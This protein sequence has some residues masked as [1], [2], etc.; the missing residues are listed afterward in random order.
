[1]TCPPRVQNFV[2]LALP[3]VFLGPLF[4]WN[5]VVLKLNHPRGLLAVLYGVLATVSFLLLALAELTGP[6][7]NQVPGPLFIL[8]RGQQTALWALAVLGSAVL[9]WDTFS[10]LFG[11]RLGSSNHRVT[12]TAYLFLTSTLLFAVAAVSAVNST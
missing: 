2:Y 3:I 6:Y 5:R 7:V 1:M 4:I 11:A 10:V 8:G 9:V 12:S